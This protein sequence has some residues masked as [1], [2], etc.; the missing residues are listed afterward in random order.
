MIRSRLRMR[1]GGSGAPWYLQGKADGIDPTF[2]ADFIN[3]RYAV[4]GVSRSYSDVFTHTRSTT[5][6]YFDSAGVMR[7][8]AINEPRLNYNPS[9][10][11][12]EGLLLEEQRTNIQ[13]QNGLTALNG[14]ATWQGIGVSQITVNATTAPDGTNNAVK[15][16]D[17]VGIT[18]THYSYN[19]GTITSGVSYSYSIYAKAAEHY[20]LHMGAQNVGGWGEFDLNAGTVVHSGVGASSITPVGNGWYRCSHYFTAGGSGSDH[21]FI[22]L[23]GNVSATGTSKRSYLGTGEGLYLWGVQDEVGAFPTSYIPTTTSAV[24]RSADLTQ[25]NAS[26]VAGFSWYNQPACTLLGEYNINGNTGA[27]GYP[28]IFNMQG[29]PTTNFIAGIYAQA[30][31]GR[32]RGD[33]GLAGVSQMQSQLVTTQPVK[34]DL[35]MAVT[36]TL[37]DGIMYYNGSA[38][39]ADTGITMPT[40]NKLNLPE[41]MTHRGFRYY[42]IRVTNSELARITT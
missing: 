36:A 26:N 31:S 7:T 18:G 37:N 4:N 16:V 13:G 34:T 41:N 10:L 1:G 12:P 42:P 22:A 24:T 32:P 20:L 30:L 2:W 27:G 15:W 3:D 14:M 11:Q 38:G 25:N 9:T 33:V 39:S 8:A 29:T 28:Q 23:N 35:K 5:G 17:R 6:T 19:F 40:L 21:L